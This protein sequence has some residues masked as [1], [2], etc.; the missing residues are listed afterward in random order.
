MKE[1]GLRAVKVPAG[2]YTA[3]SGRRGIGTITDLALDPVREDKC[4][5]QAWL[6]AGS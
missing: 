2:V 1:L 4:S 5:D 6:L 3:V